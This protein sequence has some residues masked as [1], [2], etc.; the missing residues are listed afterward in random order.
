MPQNNKEIHDHD[1]L[2]ASC[3]FCKIA[4]GEISSGKVYE[5]DET[6]AFLDNYPSVKGHTLVIPK[7][8]IENIYGFSAETAARVMITVQKLSVAIKNA[9]DADGINIV[10]NNE[11][12][13][14]Q[15][16]WHGHIHIIPRYNNDGGY[17]GEKQTY[18]KGEM[19]EIV[20]KVKA[21]I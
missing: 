15:I 14:G 13:A 8:H 17:M 2:V 9:M 20:E 5:D 7:E 11:S 18:I 10:M 3:I 16:V 21:E 19:E 6:Y 12:A 1:E 4:R